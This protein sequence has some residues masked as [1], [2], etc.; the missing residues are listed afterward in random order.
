MSPHVDPRQDPSI[1]GEGLSILAAGRFLGVPA[2]TL[3]SWERR[4]GLP[5]A[6]RSIGGHRRYRAVELI[7]LSLMRDE[8]AIGRRAGDAARRVRGLLDEENPRAARVHEMLDA[9][10]R[11]DPGAIRQVLERARA[12]I[13]L[14]AT[15]DEVLMPVMRQIGAWWETGECDVS[16]EH[17]TTEVVRAWLAKMVTLG[18]APDLSTP[19][20]LLGTGPADFHTMGLEALAA[21]LAQER[22]ASR[23]LGAHTSLPVLLAAMAATPEAVVVIVSHLSSHRRS[24][25][26]SIAAAADSGAPTF[27]AGNAF[28]FPASRKG[29]PG[30]YLGDRIGQAA[31]LVAVAARSVEPSNA[32]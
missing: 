1:A 3:R 29:V 4:Y 11:L 8:I 23:L 32:S 30:T 15:L 17:L 20:V 12:E 9:S 21:V 28:L 13:G 6:S 7:Q 2:P 22:L 27:F 26:T 31:V 18:P 24:A 10:K 5:T 16:Q 14:A 25:A 19:A